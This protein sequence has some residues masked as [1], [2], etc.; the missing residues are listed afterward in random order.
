MSVKPSNVD[1]KAR[2]QKLIAMFNALLYNDIPPLLP[3]AEDS[4]NDYD[5][6]MPPLEDPTPEATP[7][8]E[9]QDALSWT[10]RADIFFEKLGES[11]ALRREDLLRV[12]KAAAAA[13]H[14][15]IA[16]RFSHVSYDVNF[17][18]K[19]KDIK[20]VPN[21]DPGVCSVCDFACNSFRTVHDLQKGERY[22]NLN[23]YYYVESTDDENIERNWADLTHWAIPEPMIRGNQ[24]RSRTRRG[25]G[26]RE[27]R[28]T[29]AD[30]MAEIERRITQVDVGSSATLQYTAS[31][32]VSRGLDQRLRN[33]LS[34]DERLR[35]RRR[36]RIDAAREPA[37][38]RRYIVSSPGATRLRRH[39]PDLRLGARMMRNEPLTHSD[40]W[41]D[42]I[43]PRD[44]DPKRP[45]HRCSICTG[46]KSHPVSN[47]CGHSH[48][49]VCIRLW[50]ER[51]WKCPDCAQ[52][53]HRAP[54]R[55][56]S[57]E[58]NLEDVYGDWDSSRVNF[59]FDGLTFPKIPRVPIV[60]EDSD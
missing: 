34:L 45:H 38:P 27:Q 40:L 24:E 2:E 33:D 29:D 31:A 59:F 35:L 20:S 49:Y 15:K 18:L 30:V 52:T 42:G 46:V 16:S 12:Q 43:G 41:L 8:P 44:S 28:A 7:S 11:Q 37:P 50:L 53:I 5:D 54:F 55:Q 48:C 6:E 57:E 58:A 47:I 17:Q 3:V 14:Q 19:N 9:G 23:F 56:Y 39:F 13:R 25:R 21:V 10:A 60:I 4:D 36:A 51:D 22:E 32:T 26:N 1:A